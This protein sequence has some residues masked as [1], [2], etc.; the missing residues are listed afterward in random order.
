MSHSQKKFNPSPEQAAFLGWVRSGSGSCVLEAVAGAGKTTTL[1]EAC[2][3]MGGSVFLGAFN[4][5]MADELK[6]RVSGI[7]G[8]MAGTFHSAGF[9]AIRRSFDRVPEIS[10]NKVRDI[11]RRLVGETPPEG[12]VGAVSQ[13]VSLAKQTGFL[14]PDLVEHPSYRY[15]EELVYRYDV[16][17]RLEE[18]Y[19]IRQ[20][21]DH[22]IRAL[23]ESNADLRTIDFDD[24]IYLPLLMRL[25]MFQNDWVL[26]DEAQDTNAV[27]RMLARKMLR[28]GGRLIA[29]GDPHQAIYGFSGADSRSLDAIRREFDAITMQLSVSWRCPQAVVRE[30]RSWVSHI[31]AA[32]TAPEGTVGTETY[33]EMVKAAS[34]GSAILCRFNAPLLDLC[35]RFIRDGKPAKIEGRAIGEGLVALVGR[36]KVRDLESLEERLRVWNDRET[37]KLA[38]TKDPEAKLE[39]H[40]D[41]FATVMILLE[42]GREQG[43]STVADLQTMIRSM[44]EDVGSGPTASRVIV[45][46]SVHKSKGLEW[47]IV[48]ILGYREIM[49]SK[50]ARQEWQVEQEVNL[51]YVAVTRAQETLITVGMPSSG[52]AKT[53]RPE[54]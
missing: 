44:F 1:V 7:R 43:C 18:E 40:A 4:K 38:A 6:G 49:P 48:R 21:I 45:L 33:A 28:P 19:P 16:A 51:C 12:L 52:E 29:V 36:W 26:I 25:R 20:L 3:L 50:R 27:R 2:R 17:D 15:Y 5:K 22:A 54:V 8:A 39:R 47:P 11:V 37:A 31:H 13:L 9:G 30:A 24:M 32:E 53:G 35:F 23:D 41:R 34:P 10:E 42:R 14:V 46:S